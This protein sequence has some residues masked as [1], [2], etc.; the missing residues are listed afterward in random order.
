[1]FDAGLV[2]VLLVVAGA[3]LAA[4]VLNSPTLDRFPDS[5]A[6]AL[7]ASHLPSGFIS[8]VR[9]PGYP[10]VLAIAGTLPGGLNVDLLALQGLMALAAVV[11]TYY[12]GR[13]VFGNVWLAFVPSLLV[14]TDLLMAGFVRVEMSETT[15]VLLI[16]ALAAV[17]VTHLRNPRSSL[18]WLMT[19]LAIVSFLT[20]PEWAGVVVVLVPYVLVVLA[21]R[22]ALTTRMLIQVVAGTSAVLLAIG[23][24]SI[25]NL[26]VNDYLGLSSTVNVALMGKVM[27]YQME[28]EAPP[29]YDAYAAQVG[30]TAQGPWELAA[31]PPFNDRNEVLEGEFARAVILHHPLQFSEHAVGTLFA[32]STEYDS[33]FIKIQDGASFA[34]PLHA[35]LRISERRYASFLLLTPLAFVWIVLGLI[36]RKEDLRAQ[37]LGALGVIALYGWVVIAATTFG[38]FGRVHMPINPVAT[39]LIIGTLLLNVTTVLRSRTSLR[40]LALAVLA[41]ELCAVVFLRGRSTSVVLLGLV[42]VGLLQLLVSFADMR[43]ATQTEPAATI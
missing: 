32:T 29:P 18:L 19:V 3:V 27:V 21:R 20:R 31:V 5:A 6:Y 38:E 23:A 25:A 2:F 33:V 12:I 7:I 16:T 4:F 8:S 10:V 40:L 42:I 28:S 43:A 14:A 37:L 36:A 17:V 9:M 15:A 41:A 26:A 30:A 11:L 34:G 35:L 39:V 24:Y 1:M 13:V 22:G